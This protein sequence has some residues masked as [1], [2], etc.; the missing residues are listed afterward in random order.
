MIFPWASGP[1]FND[2]SMIFSFSQISRTFHEIQWS[3]HDLKT[4][5]NFNDFSS[6][7][8]TLLWAESAV[9]GFYHHGAWM[10]LTC[11]FIQNTICTCQIQPGHADQNKHTK[12]Y[13]TSIHIK[14]Q[15][16]IGVT[17]QYNHFILVILPEFHIFSVPCI[18]NMFHV[19]PK[20]LLLLEQGALSPHAYYQSTIKGEVIMSN[21]QFFP[22]SITQ[23]PTCSH[24]ITITIFYRLQN[25]PR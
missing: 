2:F 7:V 22:H 24:N 20:Q 23:H 9:K 8:G 1:K 11:C 15:E 10:S 5:L 19:W 17:D 6:A 13:I 3:F 4:D 18:S 21:C 14:S 12:Y 16:F 25:L